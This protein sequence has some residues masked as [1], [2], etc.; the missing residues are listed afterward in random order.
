MRFRT[1]TEALRHALD[2]IDEPNISVC[3]LEAAVEARRL[4]LPPIVTVDVVFSP[5]ATAIGTNGHPSCGI[6]RSRL[7][8]L[9]SL[10][11]RIRDEQAA[12][13]G[14][15]KKPRTADA[16]ATVEA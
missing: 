5:T 13:Q 4:K 10:I 15:A 8:D 1:R 12:E 3:D 2:Q 14:K 11:A 6:D 7:P 16:T 9:A